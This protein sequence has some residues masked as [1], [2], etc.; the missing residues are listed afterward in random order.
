MFSDS[1]EIFKNKT[2]CFILQIRNSHQTTCCQSIGDRKYGV[3]LQLP[4]QVLG[5]QFAAALPCL[6]QRVEHF[7]AFQVLYW[8]VSVF[9]VSL[10]RLPIYSPY[11]DS[12]WQMHAHFFTLIEIIVM[13][14][15]ITEIETESMFKALILS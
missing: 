3:C 7:V 8:I 12:Y 1:F 9:H 10:S 6:T 14:L 5:S 11:Y 4:G 2:D 13:I 15:D